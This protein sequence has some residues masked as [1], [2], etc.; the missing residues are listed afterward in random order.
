MHFPKAAAMECAGNGGREPSNTPRTCANKKSSGPAGD[1]EEIR[2][3][4]AAPEWVHQLSPLVGAAKA[5]LKT[6]CDRIRAMLFV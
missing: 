4:K 2:N 1:D 6:G 5:T 3:G